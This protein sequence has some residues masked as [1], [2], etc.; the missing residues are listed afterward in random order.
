MYGKEIEQLLRDLAWI[1]DVTY[2]HCLKVTYLM[3]CFADTPSGKLLIKQA[4]VTRNEWVASGLLHDIGKIRWPREILFATEQLKDMENEKL[5]EF[6]RCEIE[7]PLASEKVI[8][9]FYH[10][11]GNRFW[12]R[13][14]KGVAAH[15]E[16]YLGGGYPYKLSGTDI[17]LLARGIRIFDRYTTLTEVK[18][19]RMQAKDQESAL[20]EI[21]G[22]LGYEFD[23]YWGER[24]LDFLPQVELISDLDAWLTEEIRK[25]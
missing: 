4:W 8:L 24:I 15:H 12:E 18:R 5:L 16:N 23:P 25:F 14:A 21:R 2:Y 3:S 19:Y 9:D 20:K 17:P 13:I 7:H 1:D 22:L 6:W 10:Q 11:T